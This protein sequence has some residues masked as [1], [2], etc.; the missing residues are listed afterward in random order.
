MGK[1]RV[2]LA[3]V[4]FAMVREAPVV[5]GV[6]VFGW[7]VLCAAFFFLADL[8]LAM[9]VRGA[10]E[11]TYH[12][13]NVRAA[14]GG[15]SGNL[16]FL[17]TLYGAVVLVTVAELWVALP[18]EEIRRFGTEGWRDPS[19]LASLGLL[20]VVQVAD[21]ARFR[22]RLDVR[23]AGEEETDALGYRT[24]WARAGL[25]AFGAAVL[26]PLAARLGEGAPAIALLL[27][28]V[29]VLAEAF[30]SFLDRRLGLG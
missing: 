29:N 14:S 13:R 20:L 28:G 12:P 11:L 2:G 18:A 21:A 8:W 30:P 24:L 9:T 26:I 23:S 7:P 6:L 17:G 16:A 22:R 4:P 1:A 15:L 19:F 25:V 27:A 5:A 10:V 3:A